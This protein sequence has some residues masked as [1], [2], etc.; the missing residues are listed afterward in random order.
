MLCTEKKFNCSD[1]LNDFVHVHGL[2]VNNRYTIYKR[3]KAHL[4]LL[5]QI[6]AIMVPMYGFLGLFLVMVPLNG[7]A[8]L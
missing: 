8:S 5:N 4:L 2:E 3:K 7:N 6:H 1:G